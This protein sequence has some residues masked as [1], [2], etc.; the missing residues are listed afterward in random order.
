MLPGKSQVDR[1][2]RSR[3]CRSLSSGLHF[4]M[5][6]DPSTIARIALHYR[7][8][9]SI[10]IPKWVRV[11]SGVT[12]PLRGSRKNLPSARNEINQ[13]AEI[14]NKNNLPPHTGRISNFCGLNA[15]CSNQSNCF[16]A[17]NIRAKL[18]RPSRL[19]TQQRLFSNHARTT[20]LR[21]DNPRSPVGR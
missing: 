9:L 10:T 13:I 21:A 18:A 20:I 6:R 16:Q 19:G 7:Q 2:S 14:W 17:N 12:D 3:P 11:L 5:R 1:L 8:G 15:V 4:R